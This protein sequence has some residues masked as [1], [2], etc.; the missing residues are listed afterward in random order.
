MPPGVSGSRNWERQVSAPELQK[1]KSAR[2]V[3]EPN[4]LR[5]AGGG[6]R[7]ELLY[8]G[9]RCNRSNRD[10]RTPPRRHPSSRH[11]TSGIVFFLFNFRER[12]W[13]ISSGKF[14]GSFHDFLLFVKKRNRHGFVTLISQVRSPSVFSLIT[15]GWGTR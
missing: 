10:R 12:S 6:A 9:Q 7:R 14:L 11:D 4:E 5:A 13:K 2:N 3:P 8:T 1:T 15:N